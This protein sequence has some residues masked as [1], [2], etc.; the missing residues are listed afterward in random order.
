MRS[1]FADA[2]K[3]YAT[4][5]NWGL[6][7]EEQAAQHNRTGRG[8]KLKTLPETMEI[9]G[10][11]NRTIHV[12]KIDC[13]WCEW[14]TYSQWVKSGN[15]MQILVEVHNAPM[16]QARDFFYEL[17]DAG[18]VIFNKEANM[19]NGCGGAEF[20]FL[21]LHPDFFMNGTMYNAPKIAAG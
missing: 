2:L 3:G 17:H 10:H 20:G 15:L 8:M 19:F 21:K 11:T 1:H 16:P 14:F 12:F 5:H 9:L 7:T 18:Y 4:F 13:E 6:G